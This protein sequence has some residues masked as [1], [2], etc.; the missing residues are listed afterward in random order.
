M[1]AAKGSQYSCISRWYI[2]G[3]NVL[4]MDKSGRHYNSAEATSGYGPTGFGFLQLNQ[5]L[6]HSPRARASQIVLTLTSIA[7]GEVQCLWGVAASELMRYD[8]G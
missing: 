5:P 7:R 3:R 6:G 8:D 1:R 2:P 4:E